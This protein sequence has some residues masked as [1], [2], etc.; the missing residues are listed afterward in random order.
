MQPRREAVQALDEGD[1]A[2]DVLEADARRR[3]LPNVIF[4]GLQDKKA[5]PGLLACSDACL[6]HLKR[7]GAFTNVL[8]SKMFEAA[9]MARPIVLGVLGLAA[10]WLNAAGAGI[11]IEPENA[12]QLAA[13]A[14]RL[15]DDPER[16]ARFGESGRQ[17]VL[18]HHDRDHLALSYMDIA[19]RF[20]A[21]EDL[22]DPQD[23]D[24][25]HSPALAPIRSTASASRGGIRP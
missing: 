8:P 3:H 23:A 17:Y 20:A 11:C 4:T 21:P 18:A 5:V 22:G 14:E 2:R 12:D 15:A 24:D 6:V 13:A 1:H 16:R 10:E 9:G 25:R 7:R 19:R